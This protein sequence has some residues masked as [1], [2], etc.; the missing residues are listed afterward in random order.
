M[1]DVVRYRHPDDY[2]PVRM[3]RARL[4][5]YFGYNKSL[6]FFVEQKILTKENE[7]Q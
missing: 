5:L 3:E 4:L 2:H 7:I 1:K 6:A